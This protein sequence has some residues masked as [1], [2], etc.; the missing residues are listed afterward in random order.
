MADSGGV[1]RRKNMNLTTM[2]KQFLSFLLALLPLMASAD[3]VLIDGIYYN[4][5]TSTHEAEV[6]NPST[7]PYD[8]TANYISGS[9]TISATVSYNS[10]PYNVT[11]IG[12]SAF[13][14]CTGLTS[15]SIPNSVTSLGPGAFYGCSGLESITIPDN[16]TSIAEYAFSGCTDLITVTIGS[17][18]TSI[19]DVAFEN[20]SKLATLI[21]NS[22]ELTS[23]GIGFNVFKNCTGLANLH[24][25]CKEVCDWFSNI[26]SIKVV[27][28]GDNVKSIAETAFYECTGLTTVTIGS[29]VTSIGA[30]PFAGCTSLGSLVVSSENNYYNSGDNCNAIIHTESNTLIQGCNNTVIPNGITSIADG[31]FFLFVNMT[32]VNIPNSV[33]SISDQAFFGCIALT[34]I[35]IPNSVTTIGEEAFGSCISL[36]SV[37]IPNSVTTIGEKAFQN[38][39]L[40]SLEIGSGVESIGYLAFG[41]S[42]NLTTIT[43]SGDNTHFDSRGDCNA[44]IETE[45]NRLLVGC[46][47]TV[48]PDNVASLWDRAFYQCSGLTSVTLPQSLTYIEQYAFSYT[49]LTTVTIP[50]SLT[51]MG[52]YAFAW[53]SDL[54]TAT[55]KVETPMEYNYFFNDCNTPTLYV[56]AGCLTAYENAGWDTPYRHNSGT[57]SD[58]S[59]IVELN[60]VD[61]TIGAAGMGTY[62][63]NVPLDFSGTDDIKAY[64]V[65]AFRPSTGA[66]TLTRI[67]DVPANT[68]I[69]VKGAADTYNVPVGQG[70]T[71]VANML[72][73][74]T[75]STVLNK[76]SGDYTNFILAKKNGVLGFYV[77]ADGTTLG[78]HKAYLPLP[79]AKLPTATS[80][81]ALS[82]DDNGTDGIE[83]IVC[84]ENDGTFYDLQG[85]RVAKPT[86]GLYILNGKKVFIK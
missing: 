71:V 14:N 20:C 67:T 54:T 70:E 40:T 6:V 65:S 62:Y 61:I 30:A 46:K 29:G 26:E 1:Y 80:R 4:L 18:V 82:F 12:Q 5:N 55:I 74:V 31:A 37:V 11:S 73:G 39:D 44:L 64:I 81:I 10:E 48:I 35:T 52:H 45:P 43:V 15:V 68:G 19:G 47:N 42:P 84:G 79:T 75:T 83:Q 49:G 24:L 34:D 9:I 36:T 27:E 17:G 86:H 38:C 41:G 76:V 72:T 56:P 23:S 28:I 50:S 22:T 25:N 66:V 32:S 3:P 57:Y 77:V 58:F 21:I 69:V 13:Y 51:Y 85:R 8:P 59:S 33:T 78:A 2:R 63:S 7:D 16:V 53:C 60:N